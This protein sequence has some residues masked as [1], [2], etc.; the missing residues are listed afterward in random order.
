LTVDACW[1]IFIPVLKPWLPSGDNAFIVVIIRGILCISHKKAFW[2]LNCQSCLSFELL[3]DFVLEHGGIRVIQEVLKVIRGLGELFVED[4]GQSRNVWSKM[5]LKSLR[6]Y[7][8]KKTRGQGLV[9]ACVDV[10]KLSTLAS[11][12]YLHFPEGA[13]KRVAFHRILFRMIVRVVRVSVCLSMNELHA[14]WV[15]LQQ[16]VDQRDNDNNWGRGSGKTL[17]GHSLDES[18]DKLSGQQ[19]SRKYR[20][21]MCRIISTVIPFKRRWFRKPVLYLRW[22]QKDVDLAEKTRPIFDVHQIPVKKHIKLF[23]KVGIVTIE[24]KRMSIVAQR[25]VHIHPQLQEIKLT[26]C[27]Q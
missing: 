24:T 16:V 13:I 26:G 2:R 25:H 9:S 6:W 15:A 7:I 11:F 14:C 10:L 22:R 21:K 27:A 18:C 12:S 3:G 5:I 8:K 17:A 23:E 4:L 20:S 1:L 19:A